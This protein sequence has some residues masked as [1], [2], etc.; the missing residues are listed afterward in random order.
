[1]ESQEKSEA[2]SKQAR[3]EVRR[4]VEEQKLRRL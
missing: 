2:P 1:M 3:A 4:R